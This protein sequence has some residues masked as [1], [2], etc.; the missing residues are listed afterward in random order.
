[1]T[2]PLDMGE[3]SNYR[4]VVQSNIPQT[5]GSVQHEWCAITF[6]DWTNYGGKTIQIYEEPFSEYIYKDVA[7]DSLNKLT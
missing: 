2:S 3:A 5:M 4:N 1:M 7:G 6:T